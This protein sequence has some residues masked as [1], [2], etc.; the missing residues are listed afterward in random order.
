M[1]KKKLNSYLVKNF[2]RAISEDWIETYYQPVVRTS[3]GRVCEDEALARWEDPEIGVLNAAEFVPALEEAGITEK[4]DLYILNQVIDKMKKQ[5]KNKLQIVTTSINFSQVDFQSGDIVEQIDKIVS[6]AKIAKDKIAIEVSESSVSVNLDNTLDQLHRLQELGYKIEL[7]DYGC[8]DISLLL[9]PD[10]HF[11]NVKINITL[12][13]LATKYPKA[14]IVLSELVKT[15]GKIGVE[16]TV[17]GVETKKQY[18]FLSELGCA[19]LQ[20]FYYCKPISLTEVFD[21]Y[22]KG[23]QIGFENPEE[24]DYYSA[25]DKISLHDISFI[26]EKPGIDADLY[27]SLPMAIFEV[28]ENSFTVMRQNSACMEYA[29]HNFPI[30]NKKVYIPFSD[31]KGNGP[32]TYTINSIKKASQS[33]ELVIIDDRNYGGKNIHILLQRVAQNPVTGRN[34]VLF[35]VISVNDIDKTTDALTYNYI[36]R[37][38]CEDYDAM[39]FVDLETNNFVVYTSDGTNR[40]LSIEKHGEDFFKDAIDNKDGLIYEE[41][42]EMFNEICTKENIIKSIDN[43]GAFSITY[44][45]NDKKGVHYVNFKAV[46]AKGDNKHIIIEV[47]D[48]DDQVKKQQMFATLQEEKIVYSRIAALAGSIF[49]VYSVDIADNS[50]IAYKTQEGVGLIGG[51]QKG[52]DFFEETRI[53]IKELIL[54]EDYK[55]FER[56]VKK[57]NILNTIAKDGTFELR[58]SLIIAGEPKYVMFR[59][60]VIKENDESKLIVGLIDIDAQVRKDQKYKENLS[61]AEDL[62]LKDEL[63]CVKNKHAYSLAQK[64]IEDSQKEGKN[65][66]YAIVVLD[67]N[68]LKKINDTFGHQMGDEFI[69]EGCRIICEIF[70]HSPV[71]RIGGDEFSV[72]AK[73]KDYDNIKSCLAM[74]D[75][76]NNSNKLDGAVTVAFGMAKNQEACS[77]TEVFELADERMYDKKKRMKSSLY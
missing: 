16:T 47:S 46:R 33:N 30:Y 74:I 44:R 27:D 37:S 12:T 5:K 50:Y 24:S 18:E 61:A 75:I 67:I 11:D 19:K 54:K 76:R 56:R 62:A 60:V 55:E 20:G 69:K 39:Y 72:I 77:F 21:R 15:A 14:R 42:L 13:R 29:Q 59:A 40:E 10:V 63:T 9:Y 71:Y 31:A 17:K 38:L 28:D 23:L 4:L 66:K 41:D 53:R 64:E 1:S 35:A 49:A 8:S 68:G 45:A 3:N 22:E 36:A 58:Y 2:D 57:D 43:H 7:D 32:G 70:A 6:K 73:G 25:V 48:V 52:E 26:R 51:K 34:A 65:Q